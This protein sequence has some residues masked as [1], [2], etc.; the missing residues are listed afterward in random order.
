MINDHFGKKVFNSFLSCSYSASSSKSQP[1]LTPLS[2]NT[3]INIDELVSNHSSSYVEDS[4][5]AEN[6]TPSYKSQDDH[7]LPDSKISFSPSSN[8]VRMGTTHKPVTVE[9]YRTGDTAEEQDGYKEKQYTKDQDSPERSKKHY[10]PSL[11]QVTDPNT[12]QSPVDSVENS[13]FRNECEA[14]ENGHYFIST[15]PL[16]AKNINPDEVQFKTDSPHFCKNKPSIPQWCSILKNCVEQYSSV[17]QLPKPSSSSPSG[18]AGTRTICKTLEVPCRNEKLNGGDSTDGYKEKQYTKDQDS[19]EKSKEHYKPSLKHPTG[20]ICLD[21]STVHSSRDFVEDSKE[22]GA[23]ETNCDFRFISPLA[24]N[25]T[26]KN[27]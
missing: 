7:E 10:K 17:H 23:K 1:L 21:P 14:K 16:P 11:N 22:L 15:S 26:G 4:P 19:P 3:I 20:I 6:L 5:L 13:A 27:A 24:K 9:M 25:I 12:V 8:K 2:T 18:T